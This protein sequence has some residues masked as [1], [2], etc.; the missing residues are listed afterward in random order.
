MS[1][2]PEPS[3]PEQDEPA[4]G[5][6]IEGQGFILGGASDEPDEDGASRDNENDDS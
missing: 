2:E 4:D 5:E 3:D 6:E 1:D